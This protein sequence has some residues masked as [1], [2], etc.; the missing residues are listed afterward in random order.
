MNHVNAWL[1]VTVG[2]LPNFLRTFGNRTTNYIA[3][4]RVLNPTKS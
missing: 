3:C 4:L 2:A 1:S